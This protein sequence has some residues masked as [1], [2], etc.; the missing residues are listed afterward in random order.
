MLQKRNFR[1]SWTTRG[2]P[3]AV[4]VP[5][6]ADPT[7]VFGAWNASG[8]LPYERARRTQHASPARAVQQRPDAA[9]RL[10]V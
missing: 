4:I 1:A 3:A 6:A 5:K 9:V 10:T 7:V 8:P 2:S